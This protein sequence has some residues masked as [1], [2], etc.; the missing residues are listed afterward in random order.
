MRR[1]SEKRRKRYWC[2][3]IHILYSSTYSHPLPSPHIS[4]PNPVVLRPSWKPNGGCG[5]GGAVTSKWLCVTVHT[6]YPVL[7]HQR[8]HSREVVCHPIS[9]ATRELGLTSHVS[10]ESSSLLPSYVVADIHFH[11]GLEVSL[12]FLRHVK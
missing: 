3:S 6:F 9:L 10:R 7:S 1:Y 8:T 5:K 12:E 4:L 11:G 2:L